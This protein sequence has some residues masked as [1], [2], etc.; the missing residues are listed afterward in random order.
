METSPTKKLSTKQIIGYSLGAGPTAL[1]VG[2]FTLKYVELFYDDLQLLSTLFIIGQVIY[3]TVNALND[4]LTG[5]LT[6]RTNREKWGSRRLIYIKYGGP[7][8]ALTFILIWVPWSMDNQIVIFFHYVISI[9]LFDTMLSLV[10][11]CWMALLPELTS[12]TGERNKLNFI[13]LIFAVVFVIPFYLIAGPMTTTSTSFQILMIIISIISTILLLGVAILV[14]ERPE[15]Q[16]DEYFPLWKS[17]RETIKSKTFL[18]FIA[19]NFCGIIYSSLALSY[20]FAFALVLGPTSSVGTILYFLVY[21]FVGYLA[22]NLI[23]LKL[24]KRWGM[25]KVI[26]R[27]G[28]IRVI[29]VLISFLI[30]IIPGLEYFIWVGFIWLTFFGGYEVYT[31]GGLLYLAVDEDE[32]RHGIR[33][34]GMFL[35]I[36][37]LF[38]KPANSIGPIIATAIFFAFGYV[39]GTDIQS[40]TA[41]FGIKIL[42]L[43]VPVIFISI[44]LIIMYF[45]PLHGEK[46]EEMRR[47]LETIHQKKREIAQSETKN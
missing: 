25:R 30:S 8:W 44:S 24:Q 23:A 34:E 20:L 10:V 17:L 43:L 35:G 1:L 27:F 31:R 15:Y 2:I 42:F 5:Q 22:A 9:C 46:L 7:I 12:D 13:S 41:L 16:K 11:M 19:Y 6:D 40:I 39:Q 45:F 21:I 4:P 37:A 26:L 3:M 36:N 32:L 29:G 47:K 38:T 33:R 14:K 18:L 28:T